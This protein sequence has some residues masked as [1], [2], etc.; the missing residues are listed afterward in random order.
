ML[1]SIDIHS[2]FKLLDLLI[3]YLSHYE[4]LAFAEE[5]QKVEEMLFSRQ[6]L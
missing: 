6:L 1:D 5:T 4:D 2:N 3:Q